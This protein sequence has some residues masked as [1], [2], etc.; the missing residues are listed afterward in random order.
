M[1]HHAASHSG[2]RKIVHAMLEQVDT[3]CLE[4]HW[5]D[6]KRLGRNQLLEGR[7]QPW[8]GQPL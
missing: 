6:E 2:G 3:V 1:F 5:S 8:W 4:Q 7:G